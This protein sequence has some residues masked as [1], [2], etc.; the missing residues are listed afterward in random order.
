M[1]GALRSTVLVPI[2]RIVLDAGVLYS[3]SLLAML[4]CFV[5]KNRGNYVM[6]DV[7]RP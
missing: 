4:I 2:L 5:A 3:L 1:T 6:I 7:V